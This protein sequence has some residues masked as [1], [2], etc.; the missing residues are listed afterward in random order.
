MR[1]QDVSLVTSYSSKPQQPSNGGK[2]S[3]RSITF[4]HIPLDAQPNLTVVGDHLATDST[5]TFRLDDTKLGFT[6]ITPSDL[7]REATKLPAQPLPQTQWTALDQILTAWLGMGDRQ[8]ITEPVVVKVLDPLPEEVEG[9]TSSIF[10][11]VCN[12]QQSP[13]HARR[14]KALQ[15]SITPTHPF[16]QGPPIYLERVDELVW[17]LEKP[18][19]TKIISSRASNPVFNWRNPKTYGSTLKA[20]LGGLFKP[21]PPTPSEKKPDAPSVYQFSIPRSDWMHMKADVFEILTQEFPMLRKGEEE[22]LYEAPLIVP[23]RFWILKH[24][25][26]AEVFASRPEHQTAINRWKPYLLP[27]LFNHQPVTK[28]VAIKP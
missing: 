12:R 4:A 23:S 14:L 19:P 20:L 10:E 27:S 11:M 6:A 5:Q 17:S 28:P 2:A 1:V 16:L 13:F 7:A 9:L 24:L 15:N 21:I 3:D 22:H 18:Q 25:E 8:R 26:T